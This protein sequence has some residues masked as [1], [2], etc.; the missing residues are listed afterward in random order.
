M[1]QKYKR[2]TKQYCKQ[3]AFTHYYPGDLKEYIQIICKARLYRKKYHYKFNP[4]LHDTLDVRRARK[5]INNPTLFM[6]NI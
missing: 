2:F 6:M 5:I 1:K 4:I 3:L